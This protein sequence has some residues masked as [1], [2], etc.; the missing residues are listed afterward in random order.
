RPARFNGDPVWAEILDIHGRVKRS[1]R[2]AVAVPFT[3]PTPTDRDENRVR[4][5]FQGYAVGSRRPVTALACQLSSHAAI[6]LVLYARRHRW[7]ESG[8]NRLS[9]S[10]QRVIEA[11]ASSSRSTGLE[12]RVRVVRI[13]SRSAFVR[14][15]SFSRYRAFINAAHVTQNRLPFCAGRRLHCSQITLFSF[16]GCWCV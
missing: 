8:M 7:P 16:L 12:T 5:G 1:M 4:R 14:T 3:P 2:V 13:T 10:R 6:S 9:H 15:N 11:S